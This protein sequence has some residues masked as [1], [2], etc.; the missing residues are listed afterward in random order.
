M[1]DELRAAVR[2]TQKYLE[3]EVHM[4]AKKMPILAEMSLYVSILYLDHSKACNT[5]RRLLLLVLCTFNTCNPLDICTCT[6]AHTQLNSDSLTQQTCPACHADNDYITF[7]KVYTADTHDY[8]FL[9]Y[10]MSSME[11][12]ACRSL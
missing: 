12:T 8:E 1:Q 3:V 10:V 5:R 7:R 6:S 9:K 2:Q 4:I 11:C